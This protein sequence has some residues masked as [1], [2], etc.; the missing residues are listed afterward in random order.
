MEIRYPINCRDYQDRQVIVPRTT[1]E[2]IVIQH[3][4][5]R[6][7]LRVLCDA[8]ESPDYVYAQ[9]RPAQTSILFYRLGFFSGSL[10][11]EY[12]RVV[13]RYNADEH[14]VVITAFPISRINT[15]DRRIYVRRG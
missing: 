14:G 12:I 10:V 3:P 5:M 4:E 9:E 13:V 11:N 8:L 1:A 7:Y 2:H 6:P 15:S